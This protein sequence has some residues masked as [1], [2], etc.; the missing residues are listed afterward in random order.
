VADLVGRY[1]GVDITPELIRANQ[2]RCLSPRRRFLCRDMIH[3]RLPAA[4]L[5]L[6]RD[7][8]ASVQYAAATGP[9]PGIVRN[10]GRAMS[11]HGWHLRRQAPC[12]LALQQPADVTAVSLT[13][14]TGS[15][16]LSDTT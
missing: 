13:A 9:F 14:R 12:S 3:Q 8:F 4:D 16:I 5:V 6:C 15:A 10:G 7:G 11:P 1:I 2:Q